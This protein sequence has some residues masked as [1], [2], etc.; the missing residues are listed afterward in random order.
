[1]RVC[2]HRHLSAPRRALYKTLFDEERLIHLLD[3]AGIFA[4]RRG[5][6]GEADRAAAKLVYDSRK[7]LVVNLVET[8][9][10]DI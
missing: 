2:K 5:N 9:S 3:S 7:Y 6:S 1:M 10:V 8:V 4:E